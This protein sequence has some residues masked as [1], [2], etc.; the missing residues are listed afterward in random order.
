MNDAN[1]NDRLFVAR[2]SLVLFLSGV[3]VPL[4]TLIIL[5]LRETELA[6]ETEQNVEHLAFA[7]YA[8][9][10]VLAV[11]LGFVGQRHL[12]GKIG[13]FGPII[14][15]VLAMAVAMWAFFRSS[16]PRA[17]ETPAAP[18]VVEEL[19]LREPPTQ[20]PV[21]PEAQPGGDEQAP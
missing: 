17:I 1:E 4:V 2:C 6:P 9:A 3:L 20:P 8:I 10:N 15:F 11:V 12:S 18:V 21:Q 5:D 13:M 16:G 7:F 19:P 14:V